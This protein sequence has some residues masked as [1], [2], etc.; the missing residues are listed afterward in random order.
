MALRLLELGALLGVEAAGLLLV[1]EALHNR[2]QRLHRPLGL[3]LLL[4]LL[5]LLL[6]LLSRVRMACSQGRGDTA[7]V[8]GR[9]RCGQLRGGGSGILRLPLGG[10]GRRLRLRDA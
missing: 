9:R 4:L 5:R 10:G 6:R 2:L 7:N 1:Q 3:L 8:S